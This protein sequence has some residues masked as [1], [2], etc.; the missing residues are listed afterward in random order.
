VYEK[1]PGFYHCGLPCPETNKI[2]FVQKKT[3]YRNDRQGLEPSPARPAKIT[4]L[5]RCLCPD[6]KTSSGDW[7]K[8]SGLYLHHPCSR[9]SKP[10]QKE[11]RFSIERSWLKR[12]WHDRS[13]T[14]IA[15]ECSFHP[16]TISSKSLQ[17]LKNL[18]HAKEHKIL[19]PLKL[20]KTAIILP[21]TKNLPYA[22]PYVD[23]SKEYPFHVHDYMKCFD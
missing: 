9:K 11:T 6:C 18:Q 16:R 19:S 17:K 20:Q 5:S 15:G 21:S 4:D 14:N 23:P 13:L 7:Q 3:G 22:D 1:E 10:R 2:Q 12:G 8:Y